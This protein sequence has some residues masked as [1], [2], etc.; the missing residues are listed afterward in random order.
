[1]IEKTEKN[2]FFAGVVLIVQFAAVLVSFLI[3]LG[4]KEKWMKLFFFLSLIGGAAG[5]YIVFK[6]KIQPILPP[7]RRT[8]KTNDGAYNDYDDF[9]Y[10]A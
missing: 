3:S 5:M 7:S 9:C 2:R 4:H 6:E 10:D 1:M 8:K